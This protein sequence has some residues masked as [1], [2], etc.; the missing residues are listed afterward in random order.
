MSRAYLG[1]LDR[2]DP[3]YE[4]L[5]IQ[6]ASEIRDP[7][8][9]VSRLSHR[10]VFKYTEENSLI[11]VVGK[12]F[13]LDDTKPDRVYRIKC[14]YDNLNKARQYGLDRFPNYVVRPISK[15]ERIGLA[16]IEEFIS[17][18]DLDH[19]LRKAIHEGTDESL[20]K[21]L[22]ALASF[23]HV[24]HTRTKSDGNVCLD[25]VSAYFQKIIRKLTV[26]NVIPES[27]VEPYLKLMDRWL[28]GPLLQNGRGSIIHGDATP[29]N[30]IF[31]GKN[32][33][34]AIDLERMRYADAVFDIGM[35]C[36]EIK[37]AFLWRTGSLEASEPYIRHFLK[38]YARHFGDSRRVF[39][40]ITRRNPFYM[41][42]TELR[43]ARNGYLDWPYKKIL[44]HEALECL[45]W[46]LRLDD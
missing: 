31:A 8:F 27:D 42:L 20:R 38:S 40:A 5:L 22:S 9:H 44:A 17:G 43:I 41:A 11:S 21:V 28:N 33:V 32:N 4:I 13:R 23:F 16:L 18:K 10:N 35:V 36:G 37:H 30:F 29:T 2:A 19:Y 45:R 39:R 26:Q 15:D 34:V 3:L 1:I 46:G 6:I 7:V 12:F 25:S 14:E 24:L